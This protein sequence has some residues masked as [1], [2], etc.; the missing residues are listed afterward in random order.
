M[1]TI[2][3]K[4]INN[5]INLVG[6]FKDWI[7]QDLD[8]YLAYDI[9][10]N[11]EV[12][13]LR[14]KLIYSARATLIYIDNYNNTLI[15]CLLYT[16]AIDNEAEDVME[17]IIEICTDEQ[18]KLIVEKGYNYCLTDTRWQIAVII[19]RRYTVDLEKYLE[20]LK[21]DKNYYVAKRAN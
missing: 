7:G 12:F 3:Q 11:G 20:F 2:K 8:Y 4:T 18:I 9:N 6:T 16:L 15:D 14:Q 19:K 10:S 21:N 5:F 1:N 13:K 17:Y